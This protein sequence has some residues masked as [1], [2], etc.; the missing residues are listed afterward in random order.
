[1]AAICGVLDSGWC[2]TLGGLRSS[3]V[4]REEDRLLGAQVA[5]GGVELAASNAAENDP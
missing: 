5:I 4:A 3:E 1:M 2:R